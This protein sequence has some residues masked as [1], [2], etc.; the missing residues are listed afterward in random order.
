MSPHDTRTVGQLLSEIDDGDFHNEL[1]EQLRDLVAA[2]SMDAGGKRG[3]SKGA[4]TITLA[5]SAEGRSIEVRGDLKVA[6]PKPQRGKSLF[7]VTADNHLSR[8]DPNQNDLPF[9]DVSTAARETRTAI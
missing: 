4:L 2:L 7:F 5:F 6:K 8:R 9:R 1:C 3:A